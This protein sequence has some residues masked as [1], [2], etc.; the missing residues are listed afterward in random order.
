[1]IKMK[2]M[3]QWSSL[4]LFAL[5]MLSVSSCKQEDVAVQ[6]ATGTKELPSF[7][8]NISLQDIPVLAP[9]ERTVVSTDTEDGISGEGQGA[10]AFEYTVPAEGG[11]Y[12]TLSFRDGDKIPVRI[13]LY[14]SGA[15]YYGQQVFYS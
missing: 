13:L 11:N 1:M 7:T 10:R 2:K 6:P 5:L 14:P 8:T 3:N 9:E 4:L 15:A 12:P